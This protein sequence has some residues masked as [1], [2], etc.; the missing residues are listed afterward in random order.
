MMKV[1]ANEDDFEKE[2]LV[3][4]SESL[5]TTILE[6]K[7][8]CISPYFMGNI[9]FSIKTSVCLVVLFYNFLYVNDFINIYIYIVPKN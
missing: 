8:I 4:S 7:G 1:I 3:T 5:N 6:M 2:C 9:H